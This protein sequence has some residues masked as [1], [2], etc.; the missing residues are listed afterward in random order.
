MS[1]VSFI[2]SGCQGR[3]HGASIHVHVYVPACVLIRLKQLK[4]VLGS[5]RPLAP[6][7]YTHIIPGAYIIVEMGRQC[8][9][10]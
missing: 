9:T 5:V 7:K 2:S 6:N 8:Y 4:I 3:T 1:W 10:S